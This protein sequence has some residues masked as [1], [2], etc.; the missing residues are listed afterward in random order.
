[1]YKFIVHFLVEKN[2]N[3]GGRFGATSK[4]ALPIQPVWP[5]FVGWIGSVV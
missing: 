2:Q 5:I 1:M 4:R 3:P